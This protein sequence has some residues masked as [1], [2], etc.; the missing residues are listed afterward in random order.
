MEYIAVIISAIGTIITGVLGLYFKYNQK[1]KDKLTDLK[2]EKFKQDEEAKNRRRND[3]SA[4]VFGELWNVLYQLKADRV[5]IVQPHPLGNE[6]MLSI[7]YEVKRKGVEGMKDM[8]HDLKM[9]EVA[10][11]SADLSKNLF[12]YITNI[13]EQVSDKYAKA[14]LSSCGCVQVA[15]KRMSDNKHDWVGSIFCEFTHPMNVTQEVTQAVLHEAAVNIQYIL[16]EYK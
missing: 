5:Y 9:S 4:T 7:Y 3:S 8:I 15:I 14:L 12:M 6:C 2:I 1:S 13:D 16:P 11:F 10:R